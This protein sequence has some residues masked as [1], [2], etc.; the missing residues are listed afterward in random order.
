MKRSMT[1][2]AYR[3]LLLAH[4]SNAT[5]ATRNRD[6]ASLTVRPA[7]SAEHLSSRVS[8]AP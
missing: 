3:H 2:T 1:A 4:D 8:S 5:S 7:M 6:L